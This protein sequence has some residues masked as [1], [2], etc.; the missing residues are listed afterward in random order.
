MLRT[1][2]LITVED[3]PG[4]QP[5]HAG[6]AAGAEHPER[7]V[8]RLDTDTHVRRCQEQHSAAVHWLT[9]AAEGDPYYHNSD[10][11]TEPADR[12]QLWVASTASANTAM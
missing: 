12:L 11:K 8:R 5:A 7:R 6:F 3:L 2:V 1:E 9:A 4:H 10:N